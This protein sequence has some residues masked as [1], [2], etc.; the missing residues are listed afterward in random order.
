MQVGP[1]RFQRLDHLGERQIVVAER[2]VELVEHDQL[3]ARI[4]PSEPSPLLPGA[5]AAAAMSRA[6]S[7]V[8]QVKPSPSVC[9]RTM[10]PK[11]S[12][13]LRSPVFHAPLMNCTTAHFAAIADHAQH[14]AE[15][16]RRF[17]LAGAGMD[18]E[19]SFLRNRLGGDLRVLRCLAVR[20]LGAMALLLVLLQV[21]GHGS[22]FSGMASP[23]TMSRTWWALTAS[24]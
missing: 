23:A 9:Q 7:C 21:F 24:C 15:G 14:E 4:L 22:T 11:P 6:L 5:F 19:Q 20:H 17:A 8:S 18:D 16:C 12:S 1:P 2:D 13:T 3:D 10:S